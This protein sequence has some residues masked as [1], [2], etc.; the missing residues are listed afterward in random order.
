MPGMDG[1]QLA[2]ALR[3]LPGMQASKLVAITGY[4][5][6]Q[7][8]QAAAAAGFHHHLV[9]PVDSRDLAALLDRIA[10]PQ[11]GASL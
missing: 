5:G 2:R 1:F 8:R 7:E 6:E 3:G 9:K 4:G 10:R 11:S